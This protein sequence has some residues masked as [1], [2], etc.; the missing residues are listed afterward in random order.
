[1]NDHWRRDELS[2]RTGCPVC[3]AAVPRTAVA[4]RVDGLNVKRCPRCALLY[5]DPVPSDEALRRCYGANYFQA[6]DDGPRGIGYELPADVNYFAQRDAALASGQLLCLPETIANFEIN[7]R[8]VLEIGCSSGAL[9]ESLRR[10]GAARLVGIDIDE[11][12]I[13]YGRARYQV[14]LRC[15]DLESAGLGDDRFDIVILIDVLEHF[16]DTAGFFRMAAARVTDGGGM[17]ISTPN[18]QA[19][20]AAGDRWLGLERSLE[21]VCYPSVASLKR[22][23]D[24]CGMRLD[25]TWTE[26]LPV[27]LSAYWHP[28]RSRVSRI[29]HEPVV[30][31]GNAL[32]KW[33][34]AAAQS[35]GHGADLR[36]I[37]RRDPDIR[38]ARASMAASAAVRTVD[39][40]S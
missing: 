35:N 5:V 37:L 25:R 31:L 26:G 32:T 39:A 12:A 20:D 2:A 11:A 3:A 14:D 17:V 1:M 8:D 21:H 33:K 10:R 7:G 22:L 40:S 6:S 4:T 13:S 24:D 27:A 16:A 36:A 15:G 28:A 30:A 34:F 38:S 29:L 23:A 9:L 19:F 18:A